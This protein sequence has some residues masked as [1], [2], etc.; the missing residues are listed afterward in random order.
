MKTYYGHGKLLI[1]GEYFLM[2]GAWGFALPTRFGQRMEV[3][4]IDAPYLLWTSH[5]EDGSVW[6]QHDFNLKHG[7]VSTHGKDE[8]THQLL[9]FLHEAHALNPEFLK[10]ANGFQVNTYLEFP[11]E[12]GLGSSSTIIY[13]LSQ[14]AEVNPYQLLKATF[15]GSGYDIAIA[16]RGKPLLYRWKSEEPEIQELALE[17]DF[18][19][20]LYFLHLNQKTDSRLEIEKYSH[21]LISYEDDLR[22]N[23]ISKELPRVKSLDRFVKLLEEHEKIVSRTL[24]IPTQ[25]ER[26]FPDFK[27]SIKSLGAWGGDFVLAISEQNPE[28]Y[29]EERGYATLIPFKE[30]IK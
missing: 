10:K 20:Y 5:A 26:L 6:F 22:I 1:S 4:E 23:L 8:T 30:M 28:A 29:F 9:K 11:S 12:W 15:E 19:D 13:L 2:D 24:E 7:K 14:W 18:T 27:G 25:K 3:K 21:K 17:W 16:E